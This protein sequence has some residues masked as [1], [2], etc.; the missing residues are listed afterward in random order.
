MKVMN[1]AISLH[2]VEGANRIISL[3]IKAVLRV[4][5]TKERVVTLKCYYEKYISYSTYLLKGS[6]HV[7]M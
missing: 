7:F 1:K 3:L 6:S 4:L 5:E 2:Y